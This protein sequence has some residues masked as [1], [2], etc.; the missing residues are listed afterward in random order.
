MS[1]M[2][3]IASITVSYKIIFI[4]LKSRGNGVL[5]S[6]YVLWCKLSFKEIG[7]KSENKKLTLNLK[8]NI[9]RMNGPV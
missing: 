1:E 3:F 2:A 7:L 6:L 5:I 4:S 9:S 8:K